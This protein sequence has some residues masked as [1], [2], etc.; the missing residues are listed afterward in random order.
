VLLQVAG[1]YGYL[2]F[3]ADWWGGME[4]TIYCGDEVGLQTW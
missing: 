4:Y 2:V 1:I 3:L